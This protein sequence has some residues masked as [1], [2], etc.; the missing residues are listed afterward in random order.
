[1][2]KTLEEFE[3]E[4]AKGF[5]RVEELRK[6]PSMYYVALNLEIGLRDQLQYLSDARER[7]REQ[8][9]KEAAEE[10]AKA[11]EKA[12]VKKL[13]DKGLEIQEIAELTHLSI[14]EI[15]KL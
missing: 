7:G 14:E 4:I 8:G 1:M 6:D 11:I 2:A 12:T 9:R 13:K 3:M 15:E 10:R 5:E